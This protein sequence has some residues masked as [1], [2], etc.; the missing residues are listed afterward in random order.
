M[1]RSPGVLLAGLA[2]L[3]PGGA[4]SG[5]RSGHCGRLEFYAPRARCC[6]LC[7]HYFSH[8][9]RQGLEFAP[10]CGVRDDGGREEAP[11]AA[12]KPGYENPDG[13]ALCHRIGEP[14]ARGPPALPR[15][16]RARL[17]APPQTSGTPVTRTARTETA[18]HGPTPVPGGPT[19]E[20]SHREEEEEKEEDLSKEPRSHPAP[21]SPSPTRHPF[22]AG[23]V[24]GYVLAASL[25]LGS[26]VALLLLLHAW[27][28][29]GQA[30]SSPAAPGQPGPTEEWVLKPAE[31][32]VLRAGGAGVEPSA[33]PS[34]PGVGP[35][36]PPIA[37]PPLAALPL[38]RLLDQLEVLEELVLL[39]DP[40]PGPGGGGSAWGTTRHLAARYG[41]P[42]PWVTF[43]Y[44]LRPARSP[45]RALLETVVARDPAA[46]LGQL[47]AHLEAL[48]RGD[49]L[50]ALARLAWGGVAGEEGAGGARRRAGSKYGGF[51]FGHGAP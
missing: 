36:S 20:K 24:A 35:P 1:R 3:L 30:S 11:L 5:S 42:A 8:F 18:A 40:E 37:R 4:A 46:H 16:R 14:R 7:Q 21:A 17:C 38:S 41:L 25:V 26:T 32:T 39:L 27:R 33:P 44:S 10:N 22:P 28:L 50:R 23:S 6:H 2:L 47:A 29:R 34:H 15:G 48:G 31:P 49:A 19:L 51:I 45:L 12:C 9:P 13:D 43:V